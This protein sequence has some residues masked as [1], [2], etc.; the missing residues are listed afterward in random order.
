MAPRPRHTAG[1]TETLPP[2]TQAELGVGGHVREREL[3]PRNH[4]TCYVLACHSHV[5]IPGQRGEGTHRVIGHF[6]TSVICGEMHSLDLLLPY[7]GKGK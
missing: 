7:A 5:T 3:S 4:L 1:P 2:H 6:D